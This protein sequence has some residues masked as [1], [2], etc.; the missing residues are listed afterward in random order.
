MTKPPIHGKRCRRCGCDN[1]SIAGR[2]KAV[3]LAD[4]PLMPIMARSKREQFADLASLT[5]SRSL[6]VDRSLS[7]T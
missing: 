5:G 3:A 4:Y 1:A 6:G 2:R 7:A